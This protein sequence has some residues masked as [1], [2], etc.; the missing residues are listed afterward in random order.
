MDSSKLKHDF[1]NNGLRLELINKLISEAIDSKNTVEE[2]MVDDFI[3]FLN[4]HIEMMKKL[5][6]EL[7]A[8][9]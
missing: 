3:I 1:I 6:N 8:S 7:I 4:D 5:K 2:E 9:N